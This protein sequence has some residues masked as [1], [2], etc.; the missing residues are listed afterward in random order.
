[1]LVPPKLGVS[2]PRALRQTFSG[3]GVWCGI[4]VALLSAAVR[5]SGSRL[6]SRRSLNATAAVVAVGVSKCGIDP[7]RSESWC[8]LGSCLILM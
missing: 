8:P 3:F 2:I 1:M 7:R 6:A 4:E 5:L